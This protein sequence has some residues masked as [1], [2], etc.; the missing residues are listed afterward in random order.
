MDAHVGK[1]L[2]ENCIKKHLN[3]KTRILVTHQLQFIKGADSIIFLDQ[4]RVRQYNDYRELLKDPKFQ[5]LIAEEKAANDQSTSKK[6][7][8]DGQTS[9]VC[10]CKKL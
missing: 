6:C 1:H 9:K 7:S 5:A 4:G 10:F 8:E 2:F 3:G